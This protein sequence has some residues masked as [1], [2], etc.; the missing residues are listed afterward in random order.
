MSR[1]PAESW[2]FSMDAY[3]VVHQGVHILDVEVS[4][5]YRPGLGADNPFEYPNF[6]PVQDYVDAFFL[7]YPNETD[8]WE[9]VNRKLVESLLTDP[10][11]TPYGSDYWLAEMVDNVTV[12]I[13]VYPDER[14]PFFRTST[15]TQEVIVGGA[16]DDSLEGG[17][18]GDAIRSE[19]G[20]DT[21]R[22]RDGDDYLSGGAGRDFLLGGDGDD[23]LV[24]G[25]ARDTLAGAAGAD[26]FRFV[27]LD[28]IRGDRIRDF[29]HADGD[30]IDLKDIDAAAG[31]GND[32]F[33]LVASFTG[34]TGQL[35]IGDN[36]TAQVVRGDTDGDG[37][38]D[39]RIA[40]FADQPLAAADFIL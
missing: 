13:T 14:I 21:L 34:V 25:L 32:A 39:F 12:S 1:L 4:Y 38:A 20:D 28:E 33:V 2:S 15:V 19:R 5:D 10:I 31:S 6:L 7:N 11:P 22:G 29:S 26:L 40:V 18:Y 30:R 17:F 36:G 3:P 23:V 9:I 35:T 8:F 16:G 37:S 27:A 24:G